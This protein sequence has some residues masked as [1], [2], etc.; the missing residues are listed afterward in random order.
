M[1]IKSKKGLIDKIMTMI[2]KGKV[3]S[4]MKKLMK[5]NPEIAKNVKKRKRRTKK[6]I[7]KALKKHFIKLWLIIL[8]LK[9]FRDYQKLLK[10]I[11]EE[12]AKIENRRRYNKVTTGLKRHNKKSLN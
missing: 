5:Q 7:E 6:E 12:E 3:D 9:K 2:A 8:N 4:S 1:K 10:E 11:K